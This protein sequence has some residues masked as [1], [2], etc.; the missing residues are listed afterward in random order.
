M[1]TKLR[2][3]CSALPL[4]FACPGSVRRGE[5]V[6][7]EVSD[8][9]FMGR[10][11]HEGH[12]HMVETGRVDW[13]GVPELA[14]KHGV[15]E[16]DLRVLLAL[17]WK[18]WRQL[19]ESVPNASTEV[20]FRYRVDLGHEE[21]DFEL[22][23]HVDVIGFAGGEAIID[24]WKDGRVD[25]DYS[26]QWRGYA[27]LALHTYPELTRAKGGIAWVREQ[28]FE[29]YSMTRTEAARWLERLRNEVVRWDGVYRAGNHCKHCP[30]AHECPARRA[31]V[32]RDVEVFSDKMTVA[33]VEDADVIATIPPNDL[34]KGLLMASRVELA[35]KRFRDA[36]RDYVMKHGEVSGEEYVAVIQ[37]ESRRELDTAAA[38]P[39]LE[40]VL[41][42]ES[43]PK[44]IEIRISK[45]EELVAKAAGKGNGAAAK[46]RL[47]KALEDA[48]AVKT[49]VTT[50]LVVR[51]AT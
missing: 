48:G 37:H 2:L 27:F 32:R 3:R 20:E 7:D 28:D 44:A 43:M 40:S 51:R 17:G 10:A 35:A 41:D 9:A 36:V 1:G 46:R 33:R 18:L 24:D 15:E 42:D 30:R 23:G 16:K 13:D 34:I 14:R 47:S 12:A 4:A 26:E 22:T 45:L 19:R 49:S 50:K 6:I 39:V 29:P 31:L 25:K 38:W 8:A 11:A 21:A 5:L